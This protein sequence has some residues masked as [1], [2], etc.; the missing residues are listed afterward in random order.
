MVGQA[1]RFAQEIATGHKRA[2]GVLKQ[3]RSKGA[4][5]YLER[6]I[7]RVQQVM[8]QTR[9]RI[10]KGNT[11]VPEAGEFVRAAH[12]D[13]PQRQSRQAHRV[14]QDGEDSGS[15]AQ[16]VTHY[17]VYAER[18]HDS[19]LVLPGSLC[20]KNSRP[21]SRICSPPMRHFSRCAMKLGPH[22]RESGEWPSPIAPPRSAERKKFE[23]KRWFRNAQKWRTGSEGRISLF[24]RRHG[25]NRCRYKGMPDSRAGSASVSS[26]IT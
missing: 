18:P 11:H 10:F 7:P 6:M 14:W 4:Q 25:L 8:R 20:M 15:R 26:P 13:H 23:K 19:D 12:R 5:A 9:E 16:I 3:V 21:A 2:D 1:K 17:E 22:H 24:K